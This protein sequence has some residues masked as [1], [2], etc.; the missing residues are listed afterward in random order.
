MA[1]YAVTRK[2]GHTESVDLYGK[3]SGRAQKLEWY[4]GSLCKECFRK[5]KEGGDILA[6][7]V[8]RTIPVNGDYTNVLSAVILTGDTYQYRDSIQINSFSFG[9]WG[10]PT[11]KLPWAKSEKVWQIVTENKFN[12][13]NLKLYIS[14]YYDAI[15]GLTR[16]L[17]GVKISIIWD[18]DNPDEEYLQDVMDMNM[19]AANK[20]NYIYDSRPMSPEYIR[21]LGW[22]GI[23]RDGDKKCVYLS[24]G[25]RAV[26]E[27]EVE[28]LET[29][30]RLREEYK[31]KVRAIKMECITNNPYHENK[32]TDCQD[33]E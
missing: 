1:K 20:I 22:D 25:P 21:G 10:Y 27:E 29:F 11:V 16:S 24:S 30:L 3:E 13:E 19:N 33:S 2:C 8:V 31:E 17:K 14:Q 4:R 15:K 9:K 7:I 12:M 32:D 6:T 28:E 23:I 18:A 26:T 5:P